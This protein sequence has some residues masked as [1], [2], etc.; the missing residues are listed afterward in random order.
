MTCL[1]GCISSLWSYVATLMTSSRAE[2]THAWHSNC[3]TLPAPFLPVTARLLRILRQISDF[4][5]LP[6]HRL[7]AHLAAPIDIRRCH[8]VHIATSSSCC[9][10]PRV[11]S[12]RSSTLANSFLRVKTFANAFVYRAVCWSIPRVRL[13]ISRCTASHPVVPCGTLMSGFLEAKQEIFIKYSN[14]TGWQAYCR[15][16]NTVPL[17]NRLL[18][19]L[20]LS[21]PYSFIARHTTLFLYAPW[22]VVRHT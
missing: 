8:A 2:C 6:E 9:E 20:A 4:E 12:K 13:L 14:C 22:G 5:N 15:L 16:P 17:P 19:R 18:I 3:Y 11:M 21:T 10:N 7:D 1:Y